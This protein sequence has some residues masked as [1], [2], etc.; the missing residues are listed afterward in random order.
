M[1][2]MR[3]IRKPF[4]VMDGVL[5][6]CLEGYAPG[7]VELERQEIISGVEVVY[8]LSNREVG[9]LGEVKI[10]KADDRITL[11]Y[12]GE[13]PRPQRDPE[14]Y[15][16]RKAH[17][18]M[19]K[20]AF[21]DRMSRDMAME[22]RPEQPTTMR[23]DVIQ[24][25]SISSEKVAPRIGIITALPKEFAAMKALLE[26]PKDLRTKGRGAGRRYLLGDI[27]ITS[28][29]KHSI[30]L[31]LAGKGNN[32]AASRATRLLEHFPTV[33]SIIM[34]GIAGGVPHPE[35]PDEHVRL[36][37]IVVSDERGVIQYD[38]VKEEREEIIPRH[39][40][41]PPSATLIE[42]T[43]FLEVGELEGKRPWLAF[44]N[45][46]LDQL[47]WARPPEE[48]DL[49]ADSHEPKQIIRHPDDPE[50]VK[51]EP[52]VF[53]GP[54]AS[55]NNLLKDPVKRDE[56]RDRIS[57]KAVEMEGSG[58]AD[59]TWTHE[60]GYLVVR[61][62]CDYCDSN[63]GDAWQQY[64]AVVAAAYTRALLESV[65]RFERESRQQIGMPAVATSDPYPDL[66]LLTELVE[67]I[68]AIKKL[69][70]DDPSFQEWHSAV[71]LALVQ[72]FGEGSLQV[73]EYSKIAW[74][75]SNKPEN[76]DEQRILY[77]DSWIA[78]E[79][80]LK[81]IIRTSGHAVNAARGGLVILSAKWGAKDRWEDVTPTL[82]SRVTPEGTLEIQAD[83][84]VFGESFWGE[85][86][87]LKVI[88]ALDGQEGSK[89]VLED[90]WLRLP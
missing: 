27:P 82:N 42:D 41:R 79:G 59:A 87:T 6:R 45:Q 7:A 71:K 60:V 17:H 50:R 86:K 3:E 4:D 28:G 53:R 37:D 38:N 61:G 12:I 40:P 24:I 70:Y 68:P 21:L 76:A 29:G 54:I 2:S 10:R 46:A 81:A 35:K 74:H 80:L 63:K 69:D 16:R 25:E 26:N 11:L 73:T 67:D 49:L 15:K 90:E 30:V 55:A 36:G 32:S 20:Q 64:A 9:D 34:V 83:R 8:R 47:N 18:R 22:V 43:S 56:L 52:R 77:S 1:S 84:D 72:N 19:V 57:V 5:N 31:A 39:L 75:T 78:A 62:V 65:S 23:K 85:K 14:L 33:D 89:T 13:P 66:S 88:Y 58:I 48:S 51:G 44:I